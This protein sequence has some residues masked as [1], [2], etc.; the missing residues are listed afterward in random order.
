MKNGGITLTA[1]KYK[2]FLTFFH[3]FGGFCI[4][5]ESGHYIGR[6]G[7]VKKVPISNQVSELE[8]SNE[9]SYQTRGQF[10]T[11][12]NNSSAR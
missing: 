3:F 11:K 2:H 6:Y 10:N 5:G 7:L 12:N 4:L 1:I 8:I 9:N